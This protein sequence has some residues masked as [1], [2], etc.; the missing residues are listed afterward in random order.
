M[1]GG[2]LLFE[3]GEEVEWLKVY[4]VKVVEVRVL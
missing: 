4:E 3:F 2:D 1:E